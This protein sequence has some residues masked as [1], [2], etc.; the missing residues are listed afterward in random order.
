M[1]GPNGLNCDLD[2]LG[3]FIESVCLWWLSKC[4]WFQVILI[5]KCMVV[6]QTELG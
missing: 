5:L 6:L 3:D 1:V 2:D 4:K